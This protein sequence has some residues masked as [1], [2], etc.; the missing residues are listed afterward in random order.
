M[1]LT[2]VGFIKEHR[3]Y[4]PNSE[5]GAQVIGFTGLD[6]QGLEGLELSY[7]S[8]MHGQGGFLVVERDALGRGM[9]SADGRIE[10]SAQGRPLP[11]PG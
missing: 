2:G 3:R 11:D 9:S 7:D 6:P 10:G 8:A 5:I 4:Y 1:H